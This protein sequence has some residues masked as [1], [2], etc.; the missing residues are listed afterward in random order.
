M[1]VIR[2]HPT[3]LIIDG[4]EVAYTDS[5]GEGEPLLLIHGGGLADWLTP[6]AETPALGHHRVIR[7][8]RAGYTDT[9]LPRRLGI[10]DH[11]RHA[12]T[13]LRQLN[14][15]PAH[16]VAHSSGSAIALQLAVDSPTS[17]RTIT[18]CEPPLVDALADPS[19]L[20]DLHAV[21]GPMMGSAMAATAR[22]DHAEAFDA[23]MTVICGPGYRSVM[24]A[25]LGAGLVDDAAHRSEDFFTSEIPAVSAWSFDPA[26]A[27]PVLLV[28]GADSP[29][30]VSRLIANVAGRLPDSTVVIVADA[31]HLM[32][33]TAPAE[34]GGHIEH[35][36]RSR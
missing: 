8:I 14:A 36:C 27:C 12:A 21:L 18:L 6:L 7:M 26:V 4:A 24:E 3:R 17:V 30:P 1:T 20:G 16:V 28:Q 32:P 23:F 5:G 10:A 29:S 35:F 33:L 19:D 15:A 13:L 31:G 11:A 25:A 34:L 2:A 9:P 22:G